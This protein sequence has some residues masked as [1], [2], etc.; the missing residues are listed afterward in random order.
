M[1]GHSIPGIKGFKGSAL[2]DGKAAS[3]AFQMQS[4]LYEEEIENPYEDVEFVKKE[5]GEH[6]QDEFLRWKEQ[7]ERTGVQYGME[8]LV[9]M[10]KRLK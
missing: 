1:K 10:F 9:K 2:E 4:P 6:Y 7:G 5:L 8:E 3:S